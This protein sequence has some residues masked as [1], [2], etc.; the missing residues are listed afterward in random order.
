MIDDILTWAAQAAGGEVVRSFKASGGNRRQSWGI[1]VRQPD[2]SERALFIRHD[3][4][5]TIEGIEPYTIAR[6][7]EIY[8]AIAPIGLK[9][10]QYVAESRE[11]RAVLT[12]RAEG[13]AEL[14]HLK[15]PA[16]KQVIACEFMDN[17]ARL[18]AA[19]DVSLDGGLSGTIAGHVRREID[20]WDAMFVETGRPD[21]LIAFAFRWL[22]ANLPNPPGTPVIVHGDAGPGNFMFHDGHLTTLIDWE[23]CHLGDPMEDLA[24]F[25]MRCVMEPVPDFHGALRHYEAASGEP[26]DR[27]RLLYHRVLVSTRV[28]VIRH[29]NFAGEPAYAIVSRG[30]NRR[31]LID[32]LSAASGIS[33]PPPVP[34]DAPE[35][36][37]QWLYDRV[38]AQFGEFVIPRSTD[39]QVIGAAKNNAK[40]VKYLKAIDRYGPVIAAAR[41][42]ALARLGPLDQLPFDQALAWF[43]QDS[44]WEA[45]LSA[46]A[47]GSIA[48]RHYDEI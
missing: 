44:L 28:C 20:L 36:E 2:G 21:P 41:A 23:F 37:Q 33:V 38:I 11:L 3:P 4:R 7:A 27:Q 12:D 9:A 18:H 25:A 45:Q 13:I 39:Q 5:E 16:A 1:D 15:D 42:K 17:I 32:A 8:R 19:R 47:S 10:P 34:A 43:A 46:E 40:V 26:I 24:W 35:T 30:L 48:R 31:L 6:E 22:K 29:R 14:R